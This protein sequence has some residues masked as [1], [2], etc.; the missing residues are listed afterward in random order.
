MPPSLA[1]VVL[2]AASVWLT[3]ARPA[4]APA[5]FSGTW[6]ADT[7]A[8]SS[9]PATAGGMVSARGGTIGSWTP[10]ERQIEERLTQTADTLTIER[11]ASG[12]RQTYAYNLDGT[13]STNVN[14]RSTR[15]TKS[16]WDGDTLVT[17]GHESTTT[18]SDTA[19]VNSFREVRSIDNTGAMIV[20]ATRQF[21]GSGQTVSL[22][23]L[24][25]KK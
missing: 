2:I 12:G 8:G 14:G 23:S 11:R 15:T 9:A 24:V 1:R 20:E 5:N 10:P 21:E 4:H 18:A 25:K 6:I 13:E 16:R 19:I 17:E 3:M 22:L 7:A